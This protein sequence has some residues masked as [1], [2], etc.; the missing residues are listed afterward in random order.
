MHFMS[1][2]YRIYGLEYSGSTLLDIYL[3]YKKKNS[4]GLGRVFKTNFAT[5]RAGVNYNYLMGFAYLKTEADTFNFVNELGNVSANLSLSIEGNKLIWG[6][7]SDSGLT[8][9]MD[10]FSEVSNGFDLGFGVNLKKLI[11]Q[12]VHQ[13]L[14]QFLQLYFFHLNH[15]LLVDK[16]SYQIN[17]SHALNHT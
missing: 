13:Y 16:F 1:D 7:L 8:V 3:T 5:F 2:L 9:S 15:Q 17:Q 12:N 11:H 10:H 14:Y 4:I 6:A